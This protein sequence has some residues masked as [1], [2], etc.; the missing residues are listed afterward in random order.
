MATKKERFTALG[1]YIFAGGFTLGV[2]QHFKVLGHL[3]DGPF[4]V[5]TARQ[6][7]PGM[8]IQT[9][10]S[11]WE[12][13]ALKLMHDSGRALDLLYCNPPC[14]AWSKA[15][16]FVTKGRSAYKDAEHYT[17]CTTRAADLALRL[18][19]NIWVWESVPQAWEFGHEFTK[20]LARQFTKAGYLVTLLFTDL[21]LHGCPQ[22]RPRFHFV[23]SKLHLDYEDLLHREYTVTTGVSEFLKKYEFK[24]E[25]VSPLSDVISRVIREMKKTKKF[26][27]VRQVADRV[28]GGEHMYPLRTASTGRQYRTG[29]PSFLVKRVKPDKTCETITGGANLIHPEKVRYL[30]VEEQQV[31]G[32]WPLSFKFQ[33]TVGSQYAQVGKAVQPATGEFIARVTASALRMRQPVAKPG[34]FMLDLRPVLSER[35]P[36]YEQLTL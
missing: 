4:G 32:G 12:I 25:T 14:A 27:S 17:S 31:L 1:N 36:V 8:V 30:S 2:E 16:T 11:L 19:P 35:E 26:G 34:F 20:H 5:A 7:W 23:A 6:H 10:P 18:N 33:G 24:T 29:R 3:E 21:Q 13:E 22:R 15:G 9:S 28:V